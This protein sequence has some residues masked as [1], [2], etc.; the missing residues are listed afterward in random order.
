MPGFSCIFNTRCALI[1]PSSANN[2]L[3]YVMRQSEDL[4]DE[5]ERTYSD[6]AEYNEYTV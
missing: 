3:S 1:L 6:Q 4:G 5:E 2:S